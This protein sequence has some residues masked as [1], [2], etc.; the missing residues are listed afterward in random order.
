M[1]RPR[2]GFTLIELL[3]VIAIIA[4]LIGLLLPAVQKVREAASRM[5]CQN[6]LKQ[7]GLALHNYHDADGCFPP[8]MVVR[9]RNITDAERDRLHLPA[10]LPG[11]GQ[12]RTDCTTSSSRG[13]TRPTDQAVGVEVQVFFCPSNRARRSIDLRAD[14]GAVE[15]VRCR[16]GRPRCDYAFCKGANGALHRDWTRTPLRGPRRLQHPAA[17]RGVAPACRIA[18]IT[19]G[20]SRTFAMGDAAG[21]TPHYLCRD[22]RQPDA[23]GDRRAHGPAGPAWSSRGARPACRRP[24]PSV[25]RLGVRGDGPVRPGRPTRATSR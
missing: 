24:E 11:A 7:L 18:D 25:V 5:Q 9:R 19:D 20:T 4:I 17:R 15:H 10:A 3:V 2:S 23:A 6:N 21:G 13:T 12:H 14:R 16:R 1:L 8:G 22:L